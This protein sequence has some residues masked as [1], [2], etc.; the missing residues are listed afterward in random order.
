MEEGEQML[1]EE[2]VIRKDVLRM[3]VITKLI[4]S[5][6]LKLNNPISLTNQIFR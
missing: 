6:K 3:E 5:I 4:K 2:K 1:T